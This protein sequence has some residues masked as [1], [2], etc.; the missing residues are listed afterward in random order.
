MPK[1]IQ[2]IDARAAHALRMALITRHGWITR[3]YPEVGSPARMEALEELI[4]LTHELGLDGGMFH[5]VN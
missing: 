3:L 2:L 5:D 4:H 1:P